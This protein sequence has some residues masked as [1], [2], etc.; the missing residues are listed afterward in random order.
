MSF[1][2]GRLRQVWKIQNNVLSYHMNNEMFVDIHIHQ[3]LFTMPKYDL[4][5][6]NFTAAFMW[7]SLAAYKHVFVITSDTIS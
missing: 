2:N 5:V 6:K 7:S 3:I 1:Q 4:Q